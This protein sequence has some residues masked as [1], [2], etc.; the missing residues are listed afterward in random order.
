MDSPKHV[1]AGTAG[2]I[3]HGKSALIEALTGMNPDRLEEERRR[4]ITIDLGFAFLELGGVRFGFVDVPGHERFVRNMLAGVGGIDLVVLVIAA[5]ESIKPQTREHFDICRLLGIRSGLVALTKA[6]L[7]E[8]DVL[9]LA[10]LEVEEFVRGSF[11]EGAPIVSVSAKTGAGLDEL[12]TALLGV[13]R[14]AVIKGVSGH[15]RLPIDRSFAMKGFGTVVTGTLVSGSLA[16]GAEAEIY[17]SLRSVRVRGLHSGG[18]AIDRAVAGQRTAVNLAGVEHSEIERGMVLAPGGVFESTGRLDARITLLETAKALKNRAQVHFHQGTAEAIAEVVLVEKDAIAPGSSEL[19]QLRLEKEILTL[20]GDRFI[21]RQFSPVVTIGGGVV[22]DAHALRHRRSDPSPVPYLEILERGS[23]EEILM[24]LLERLRRP[25]GMRELI[26]RTGWTEAD[27][28]ATAKPLVARKNLRVI[29]DQPMKIATVEL[30]GA[31]SAAIRKSVEEF[32]RTNPLLPGI[33]KQ[34]LR[35]RLGDPDAD[36]F[37]VALDDAARAGAATIGGDLVQRAGREITL[38]A[39]EARAKEIIEREFER[40]GLTVPSFAAVL[41]KLP[42]ERG[43]AQKI[44]QILL[45]EKTLIKVAEDLA[46]HRTAVE[47]LRELVAGFKK[48]KGPSLPVPAFKELTGVTRKYAI[49]L[50]EYLDREHVTRRVG[51]QRVIL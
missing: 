16:V 40:A 43:R 10:R 20:P 30:L 1:I 18:Q 9:G 46:F 47:R 4:G 8:A 11:L 51:E 19:A 42:V 31:T 41:E 14:E 37:G 35:G 26:A 50:L 13:A 49:P 17:P 5:D 23:H 24:A 7:V 48:Q 28:R 15:F 27:I 39:E 2:H 38:T 45:R 21:L 3:D 6:D 29:A 22:I 34:E 25:L 36:L 32:H 44:F 33:P 12:K